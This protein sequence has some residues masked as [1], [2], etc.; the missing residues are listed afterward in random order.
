MNNYIKLNDEPIEIEYVADEHQEEKDFEPSFWLAAPGYNKRYY[1][2][3][4][5]RTHDNPWI[6]SDFPDYI[7]GIESDNYYRPIY[8]EI[9]DGAAVN[10]YEE[11]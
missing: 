7:H 5:M 9:I 10:V 4:F 3:D 2:D 1:L 8:I 11:R 6:V